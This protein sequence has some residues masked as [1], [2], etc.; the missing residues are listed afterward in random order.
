MGVG[1]LGVC[2]GQ[3]GDRCQHPHGGEDPADDVAGTAGQDQ[4]ADH[5]KGR[6]HQPQEGFAGT[7]SQAS[8][9]DRMATATVLP[10]Q[11][12]ANSAQPTQF[13]RLSLYKALQPQG[14]SRP[15]KLSIIRDG[16]AACLS[17]AAR[18][19]RRGRTSRCQGSVGDDGDQH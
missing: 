16:M 1:V 3:P 12:N 17:Q 4:A 18:L 13:Q 5:E 6:E 11:P 15:P 7:L 10:T 14:E 8:L 19:G 2:L 9:G